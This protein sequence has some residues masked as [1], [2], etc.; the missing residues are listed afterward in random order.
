MQSLEEALSGGDRLSLGGVGE[1]IARVK[2][3]PELFAG[4]LHFMGSADPVVAMR[5]SDAAE[6]LSRLHQ[7]WPQGNQ[8]ELLR[9]GR[10]TAQPEVRWHVAPMLTRVPLSPGSKAE[11]LDLLKCYLGD[12]SKI[13]QAEAMEAILSISHG[14]RD[15]E[16]RAETLVRM[17]AEQ[18]SPAVQARARKLMRGQARLERA[19]VKH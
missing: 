6:K 5:A 16:Y 8:D 15:D 3:R 19:N 11:A 10:H 1:V 17:L 2:A 13:V 7:D 14:D 18:G 9:V 4:L 12:R